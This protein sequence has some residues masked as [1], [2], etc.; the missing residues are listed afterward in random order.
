MRKTKFQRHRD[1]W[2][3]CH[4]C[5]LHR[6]RSNVVLVRGS[7]PCDVL[8]VGEGPGVSEDAL[9]IPFVGPAGKL[10]DRMI[11]ESGVDEYR[12]A[13]TNLVACIPKD[14]EGNKAVEPGKEAIEACSSRLREIMNLA[15]PTLVVCV[16]K[17]AEKH[18]PESVAPSKQCSIIHP[19]AILRL[20]VSQKS[21]AYQRNVVTLR[22]AVE[23][24]GE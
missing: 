24:L 8:F 3:N 10:L 14:E 5:S 9:G 20:D 7:L 18:L 23:D 4:R 19:A 22:D 1:A 15:V 21:L 17:L 12:Y 2:Q 16:G 6:G 13:L 11:A